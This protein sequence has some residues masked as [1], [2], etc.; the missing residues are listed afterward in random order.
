LQLEA[1]IDP[2]LIRQI[3]S[4]EIAS[5]T[6]PVEAVFR[7]HSDDPSTPVS[8]P[9]KTTEMVHEVLNRVKRRTGIEP[10]RVNVFHNL[11]SFAIAA[12]PLFLTELMAEPEI[13]SAMANRQPAHAFIEPIRK[14]PV[15]ISQIG[16]E[17]SD[18]VRLIK[19]SVK[20]G[21]TR[22]AKT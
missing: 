6:R 15:P 19:K 5:S 4:E 10:A 17:G 12:K 3:G 16:T 7:L 2:E 11:G 13:A 20:R 22:K 8:D 14:Q 18:R 9:E 21:K 1:K